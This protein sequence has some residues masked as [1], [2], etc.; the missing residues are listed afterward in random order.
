[1]RQAGEQAQLRY[2]AEH[3]NTPRGIARLK[4]VLRNGFAPEYQVKS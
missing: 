1:V 3:L 4:R 2:L